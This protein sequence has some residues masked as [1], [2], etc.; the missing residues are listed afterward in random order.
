MPNKWYARAVKEAKLKVFNG[1]GVWAKHVDKAVSDFNNLKFPV[2]YVSAEDK[3][4]ADVVVRMSQGNDTE[5]NWAHAN[6]DAAKTHGQTVSDIDKKGIVGKAVVFLPAKLASVSDEV[7]VVV[8][9]HELI[10]AAGLVQPNDHET[11]GIMASGFQLIDGKLREA[12]TDKTLQ[13][14]P[15]IRVGPWTICQLNHLWLGSDCDAE[16]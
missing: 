2:T 13:G 11:S 12:S 6:F 4:V 15:P 7:K 16:K 8:T 5:F 9:L 14:M 10:H 1:A 3:V